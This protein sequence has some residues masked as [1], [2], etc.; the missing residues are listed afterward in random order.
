MEKA[1]FQRTFTVT[2]KESEEYGDYVK[3]TAAL[4]KRP[5]MTIH[6]I[7]EREHWTLEQ[8]KNRYHTVISD[9][10]TI[11]KD[12]LWWYLRRKDLNK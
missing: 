8:I 10:G 7:F 9:D 4:V 5:Y 6:K 2:G 11:P 1:N 12:V 3:K